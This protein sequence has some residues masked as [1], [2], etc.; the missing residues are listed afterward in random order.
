MLNKDLGCTTWLFLNVRI[1]KKLHE[2]PAEFFQVYYA[3]SFQGSN[4]QPFF[5]GWIKT[6]VTLKKMADSLTFKAWY[7]NK[8]ESTQ[9]F[10]FKGLWVLAGR[11]WTGNF[12]MQSILLA[13][14]CLTIS[15]QQNAYQ[16]NVILAHLSQSANSL[17]AFLLGSR[18][19]HAIWEGCLFS[20]QQQR[21]AKNNR[22]EWCHD[23]LIF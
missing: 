13:N 11:D 5:S 6:L 1:Q 22:T 10:F 21:H 14:H 2:S 15:I 23:N 20:K 7:T 8:L 19:Q 9:T 16:N 12:N 17:S 18:D 3:P 4:C